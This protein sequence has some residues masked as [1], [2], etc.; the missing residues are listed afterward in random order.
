MRL[1]QCLK[2]YAWRT[3][4]VVCGC[5]FVSDSQVPTFGQ[6]MISANPQLPSRLCSLLDNEDLVVK[7][8]ICWSLGK[9]VDIVKNFAQALVEVHCIQVLEF[10]ISL[11]FSL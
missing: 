10:F 8:D 6:L 2:W 9:M 4:S 3:S 11:F 1:L 7:S 5:R